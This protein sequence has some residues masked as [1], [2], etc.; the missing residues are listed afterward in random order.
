MQQKRKKRG[1]V[2]SRAE[3]NTVSNSCWHCRCAM[4]VEWLT[5]RAEKMRTRSVSDAHDRPYIATRTAGI[6]PFYGHRARVTSAGNA[7]G[8][9]GIGS[10]T[11]PFAGSSARRSDPSWRLAS[12]RLDVD[13]PSRPLPRKSA[14]RNRTTLRLDALEVPKEPVEERNRS[15]ELLEWDRPSR[16]GPSAP[17]MPVLLSR[18]A[19]FPKGIEP[20][21]ASTEARR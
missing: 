10:A 12:I 3:R 18:K 21:G 1:G 4:D 6:R 8:P 20:C 19:P 2:Y 14:K 11:I 9:L 17:G 7:T 5:E 13:R 16:R 15:A